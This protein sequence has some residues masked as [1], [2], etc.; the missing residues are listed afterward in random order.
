[1]RKKATL[2]RKANSPYIFSSRPLA[3]AAE[4][5]RF[6]AAPE[7]FENADQASRAGTGYVRRRLCYG[8]LS[9]TNFVVRKLIHE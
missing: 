6:S 1:M 7:Q 9:S 2:I 5:A 4:I 8:S 3:R